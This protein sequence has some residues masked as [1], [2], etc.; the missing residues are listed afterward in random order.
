MS[1]IISN[2][3]IA[4]SL[5]IIK[6]NLKELIVYPIEGIGIGKERDNYFNY[7][8]NIKIMKGIF[9]GYFIQML[10][11]FPSKFPIKPPT[12]LIYPEQN[13]VYYL[14]FM[15]LSNIIYNDNYFYK[16]ETEPLW[17]S[18]SNLRILLIQIQ[19]YLNDPYID[20]D[21]YPNKDAI[22]K[23]MESMDSYKNLFIVNNELI[24]H[25]WKNP[26][27]KI[28]LENN[29]NKITEFN[30]AD[31]ECYINQLK[32]KKQKII[33][34]HISKKT[35]NLSDEERNELL[36]KYLSCKI[37]KI[38]YYDD[39]NMFGY[40]ITNT[41]NYKMIPSNELISFEAYKNLKNEVNNDSAFISEDD[42]FLPIYL[43]HW[44]F[45]YVELEYL[46]CKD[47]K[48]LLLLP[49]KYIEI[50]PT[51][52]YSQMLKISED[53]DLYNKSMASSSIICLFHYIL[54]FR[55]IINM[56]KQEY[57]QYLNKNL[58]KC[59][60]N[61][62]SNIVPIIIK[63][64]IIGLFNNDPHSEDMQKISKYIKLLKEKEYLNRFYTKKDFKMKNTE[65]FKEDLH[66]S[67]IFEKIID[68][69]MSNKSIKNNGKISKNLR[70]K[71]I[72]KFSEMFKELYIECNVDLKNQIDELILDQMVFSDYF[73][74]KDLKIN[75][76][77]Y[78]DLFMVFFVIKKQIVEKNFF[79]EL[80][81]DNGVYLKWNDFYEEIIR[82]LK[83]IKFISELKKYIE[84]EN[85]YKKI[86][87]DFSIIEIYEKDKIK[88]NIKNNY[89]KYNSSMNKK[90]IKDLQNEK[91]IELN[92]GI[93]NNTTDKTEGNKEFM[94]S[95]YTSSYE[96][97]N[98]KN[99]KI[100]KNEFMNNSYTSYG[101]S[102]LSDLDYLGYKNDVLS[103]DNEDGYY[104]Y[105]EYKFNINFDDYYN[106]KKNKK[107]K[108]KIKNNLKRKKE[109]EEQI[110]Q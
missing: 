87:S 16:F 37:S 56:H 4:Y 78:L 11:M 40:I 31:F 88:T 84:I 30:I 25:T 57:K 99:D 33:N 58:K 23:L 103:D 26:Y 7:V 10:I 22:D 98:N 91:V 94:N 8:I 76:K 70:K 90:E 44:H 51:V 86:V 35:D 1:E 19:N 61:N 50:L 83:N 93:N 64:F 105:Y 69:I 95:S 97:N 17:T 54:L 72:S 63:L 46:F 21:F 104:D 71:I 85:F 79:N 39:G 60:M 24:E 109:F 5:T 48:N 92:Y 73:E 102:Y 110:E 6:E 42:F 59:E 77:D 43:N 18:G 38:N 9:K 65:K 14:K 67:N 74:E 2:K 47:E 96:I 28:Y 107:K 45:F 15:N 53:I 20:G 68:I 89:L 100:D 32:L 82:V 80:K 55:Q 12:I 106:D 36:K 41:K 49:K 101:N 29:K 75:Y 81:N 13:I 3:E 27:P 108:F 34:F 52:L 62:I 66:K